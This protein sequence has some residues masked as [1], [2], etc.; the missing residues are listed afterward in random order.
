MYKCDRENMASGVGRAAGLHI[1]IIIAA[2]RL[3]PCNRQITG[4]A[5]QTIIIVIYYDW[6]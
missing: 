1:D 4:S 5:K 2:L 6:A 3:R